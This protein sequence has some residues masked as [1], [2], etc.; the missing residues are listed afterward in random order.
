[1]AEALDQE[2]FDLVLGRCLGRSIATLVEGLTLLGELCPDWAKFKRMLDQARSVTAQ[3]SG[4]HRAPSHH[5]QSL[6]VASHCCS[7][8][9]GSHTP[10]ARTHWTQIQEPPVA[11]ANAISPGDY[12][13]P[14]PDQATYLR[15]L[16][17]V[18]RCSV[19]SEHDQE[20]RRDRQDPWA[21]P[22]TRVE[23]AGLPP[24][25]GAT[26]GMALPLQCRQAGS[27]ARVVSQKSRIGASSA[28]IPQLPTPTLRTLMPVTTVESGAGSGG[29]ALARGVV[30]PGRGGPVGP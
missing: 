13:E 16:L 5:L 9:R 18:M 19:R 7:H 6:N 4:A 10:A 22:S 24:W 3:R 27:H 26:S 11:L 12:T 30:G 1:M 28:L 15:S 8:R 14:T 2:R 25:G 23:L 17:G 20:D 21:A 29:G